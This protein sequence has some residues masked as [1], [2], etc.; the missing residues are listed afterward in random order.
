M[1][2]RIDRHKD[3]YSIFLKFFNAEAKLVQD[4]PS[5]AAE[6]VDVVSVIRE[7]RKTLDI[8]ERRSTSLLN[9]YMA[10]DENKDRFEREM[11]NIF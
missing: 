2:T 7:L 8:L 11:E 3:A 4:V 10:E 1:R 9:A 5:N 6:A